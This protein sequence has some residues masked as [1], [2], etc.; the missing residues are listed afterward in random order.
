MLI[1]ISIIRSS[2]PSATENL[3]LDQYPRNFDVKNLFPISEDD[4]T[5]EKLSEKLSSF[6]D[7]LSIFWKDVLFIIHQNFILIILSVILF[8]YAT[9]YFFKKFYTSEFSLTYKTL[10][11]CPYGFILTLIAA[12][13][14]S[15][16]DFGILSDYFVVS[17]LI[18][19]SV[20]FASVIIG[21]LFNKNICVKYRK[22]FKIFTTTLIFFSILLYNYDFF[23][24]EEIT[25]LKDMTLNDKLREFFTHIYELI[26]NILIFLLTFAGFNTIVNA[27][28]E[29]FWAYL[30]KYYRIIRYKLSREK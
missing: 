28:Y 15:N 20:Y 30:E 25:G 24:L 19:L 10:K 14:F 8:L 11:V 3:K 21:C 18:L 9:Y 23:R 13:T 26:T 2:V 5:Q 17:G 12:I 27:Y 1:F 4:L 6:K 7:V 22:Y 29:L 16:N